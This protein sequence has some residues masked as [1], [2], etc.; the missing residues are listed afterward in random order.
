MVVAQNILTG[1]FSTIMKL[2]KYPTFKETHKRSLVRAIIWRV[3]GVV[4]LVVI[5]YSFTQSLFATSLITVLHHGVFVFGYYI[6]E[7]FWL[8]VKW[9]EGSKWKSFARVALYEIVL[10]NIILGGISYIV[11]GSLREMTMITLTY[12][13]NKYWIYYAYDYVWS[14]IKWQTR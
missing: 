10:A 9:L 8:R 12:T 4:I 13:F 5:T 14:R 6:H 11:T 7:R 1:D 2:W 3:M